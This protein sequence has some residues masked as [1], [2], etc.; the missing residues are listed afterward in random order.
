MP[1]PGQA[2]RDGVEEP[3]K[4]SPHE[5]QYDQE[6][7]C[8]VS[9]VTQALAC[10]AVDADGL[11][12]RYDSEGDGTGRL[13]VEVRFDGFSGISDGWSSDMAIRDFAR[14]LLTYPLRASAQVTLTTGF[15]SPPEEHV[16]LAV[17]AVGNRGQVGVLT[18]L[19]TPSTAMS[20]CQWSV[21][22]VRVEVLTSY[23]ALK[24]F[25]SEL[26]H[27]L[28]RDVAEARLDAE[29]LA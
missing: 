9:A 18:H 24:R 13:Q 7:L 10:F 11:V 27:L 29:L 17:R 3:S 2:G 8:A 25:S 22:E 26:E 16:G 1:P 4:P 15:D 14:R 5:S 23:E 6:G 21:S 20:D 12:V 28:R 19:A